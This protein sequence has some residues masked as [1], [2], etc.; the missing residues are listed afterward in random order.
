MNAFGIMSDEA[1]VP[2]AL[3]AFV[4]IMP[5]P[6]NATLPSAAV[7]SS[8]RRLVSMPFSLFL[9]AILVFPAAK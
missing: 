2:S 1:P 3:A 4:I 5:E 9:F 7:V 6:P 8:R